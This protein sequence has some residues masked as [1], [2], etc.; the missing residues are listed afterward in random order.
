MVWYGVGAFVSGTEGRIMA[1]RSMDYG[2]ANVS[3]A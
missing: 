3:I 1:D 2:V